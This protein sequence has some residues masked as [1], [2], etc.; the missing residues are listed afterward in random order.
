MILESL[1]RIETEIILRQW[2]FGLAIFAAGYGYGSITPEPDES[3][4]R[5]W[6]VFVRNNILV[7]ILVSGL[8]I[9]ISGVII[10]YWIF[11]VVIPRLNSN[12]VVG[13]LTIIISVLWAGIGPVIAKWLSFKN[14][15]AVEG[16]NG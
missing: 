16:I 10:D 15:N 11:Q 8:M 12:F 13:V 5:P 9:A 6:I 4:M 1:T 3:N 14:Y 7:K 2:L